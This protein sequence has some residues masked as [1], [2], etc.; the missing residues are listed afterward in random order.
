MKVSSKGKI[1]VFSATCLV[2]MLVSVSL[3]TLNGV[4]PVAAPTTEIIVDN[5][6]ATFVGTWP[7]STSVAGF[8]GSNYQTHTAGS[9]AST[10]TWYFSIASAGQYKVYARWTGS[11]NRASN[12]K[13]TVNS[14]GGSTLKTVSQKVNG[15]SWQL[16][17]TFSFNAASYSVRL[18]DQ[19]DGYVIA[20]AIRLVPV[21]LGEASYV[22]VPA[23]AFV[24]PVSNFSLG[25]DIG[26][27]VNRQGYPLFYCLAPLQLPDGVTVTNATFYFYDKGPSTFSFFVARSNQQG[28]YPLGSA[29][30]SGASGRG[31]VSL[32][33]VSA[34]LATVNNKDYNYVL[35]VGLPYSSTY[36]WFDFAVVEY[37]SPA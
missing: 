28:S 24:P 34:D 16:L 5:P 35:A 11:S 15:G 19:A 22:S 27:M 33:S 37:R 30:S 8:S 29:Y 2:I 20:D 1:T 23:C 6:A 12:A 3:L 26:G 10:A 36:Y 17:G 32:T 9:G 31:N 25:Y 4:L 13:Y 7:T 14:A 18:T 21:P